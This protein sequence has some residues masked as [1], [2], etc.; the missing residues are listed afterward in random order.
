MKAAGTIQAWVIALAALALGAW[1]MAQL[2]DPEALSQQPFEHSAKAGDDVMLRTA[3]IRLLSVDA[4][5]RIFVPKQTDA[6]GVNTGISANGVFLV[7][8]IELRGKGESVAVGNLEILARDGRVFGGLQAI[9]SNG[10]GSAPPDLPVRC[11]LVFEVDKSA[12]AG[13]KLL[14]PAGGKADDMAVIDLGIDESKARQLAVN[15]AILKI[16]AAQPGW[17]VAR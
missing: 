1:L 8:T 13:A 2:P 12:L 10:C 15:Q 4:S 17:A 16:S 14:V 5:S 3:R 9:G 7:P 6:G 11:Q